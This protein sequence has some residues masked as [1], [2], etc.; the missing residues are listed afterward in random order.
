MCSSGSIDNPLCRFVH[1][2]ERSRQYVF[3]IA[4]NVLFQIFITVNGKTSTILSAFISAFK[5]TAAKVKKA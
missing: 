5:P 1:N 3:D 2:F 4:K